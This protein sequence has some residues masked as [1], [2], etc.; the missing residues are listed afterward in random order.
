MNDRVTITGNVGVALNAEPDSTI[1]LHVHQVSTD[2]RSTE[3]RRNTLLHL[4]LKECTAANSKNTLEKIALA[5]YGNS[6]FKNLTNDQ[7]RTLIEVAQA[8]SDYGDDLLSRDLTIPA[9][10]ARICPQC[11]G[12]TWKATQLCKHCEL[13]LF[14]HDQK[15]GEKT[16]ARRQL[17]MVLCALGVAALSYLVG[18][19]ILP[20]RYSLWA[21]G[22]AGFALIAA[23]AATK[24]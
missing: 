17:V 8:I 9:D 21:Y 2:T 18:Q 24:R 11:S 14:R 10:Q 22:M 16:V 13:D 12:I 5:V 19:W 7:L 6:Y 20:V 23:V 3:D 1:H 4:L 15:V